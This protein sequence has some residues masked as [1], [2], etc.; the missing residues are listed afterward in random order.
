M[1]LPVEILALINNY[2]TDRKKLDL[3]S[4]SV[5]TSRDFYESNSLRLHNRYKFNEASYQCYNFGVTKLIFKD[6]DIT[7]DDWFKRLLYFQNL[8]ILVIEILQ[9]NED[10]W[11][12]QIPGVKELTV[13]VVSGTSINSRIKLPKTLKKF[14]LLINKL[15]YFP[16]LLNEGLEYLNVP[17]RT[18]V[19]LSVN[20]LHMPGLQFPCVEKIGTRFT[21]LDSPLIFKGPTLTFHK[22]L[23][24]IMLQ[25]ECPD[26]ISFPSGLKILKL[27]DVV[28][29]TSKQLTLPTG[30]ENI[31]IHCHGIRTAACG[32]LVFPDS[33]ISLDLDL[34][35]ARGHLIAPGVQALYISVIDWV[36]NELVLPKLL[37]KLDFWVEN[38]P[39]TPKLPEGLQII[40]WIARDGVSDVKFPESVRKL[41]V[42]YNGNEI[43][44]ISHLQLR[45]LTLHNAPSPVTLSA[46][47]TKLYLFDSQ[48]NYIPDTV[49]RLHINSEAQLVN[50]PKS[51]SLLT[52]GIDLE[53]K[54]LF[55]E[56]LK[57]S[58]GE[59]RTPITVF[60][61]DH[62]TIEI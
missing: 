60:F 61:V 34:R 26:I 56:T 25:C 32:N 23:T 43:I 1:E 15:S 7:N 47:L 35:E 59:N 8:Q 57:N 28:S 6:L 24:A 21:S 12:W 19:P 11:V 42:F 17:E 9:I 39:V 53:N 10:N 54:E 38:L 55:I 44:D 33:A 40:D 37:K 46:G 18:R 48:V 13:C 62:S 3:V 27:V 52:T 5:K 2:L 50:I 49:T 4:S 58:L 31:T 30:I 22:N 14:T 16:F 36:T 45:K 29:A 41:C 51:L 20:E